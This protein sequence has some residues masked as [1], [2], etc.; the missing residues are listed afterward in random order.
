MCVT[1]SHVAQDEN[2]TSPSSDPLWER[3]CFSEAAALCRGL[4]LYKRNRKDSETQHL[5]PI[6]DSFQNSCL[7]KC[8]VDVMTDLT[9][10]LPKRQRFEF[11]KTKGL[12]TGGT[13]QTDFQEGRSGIAR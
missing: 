9:A 5:K 7:M 3:C 4:A 1:H 8:G 2:H 6:N 11:V 10:R 12:K 13:R